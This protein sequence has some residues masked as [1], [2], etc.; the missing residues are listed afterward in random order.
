MAV[1]VTSHSHG[2]NTPGLYGSTFDK[3]P[4]AKARMAEDLW[5]LSEYK[6]HPVLRVYIPKTNGKLR[7][8]GLP[9]I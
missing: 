9:T 7:S 6:S 1:N 2:R 3:D 5:H 8:L 4:Q